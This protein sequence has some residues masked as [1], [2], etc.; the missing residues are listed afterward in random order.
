MI[1][2]IPPTKALDISSKWNKPRQV[3]LILAQ[4][5]PTGELSFW[6]SDDATGMCDWVDADNIRMAR[7]PYVEKLTSESIF[8]H[9]WPKDK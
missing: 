9:Y 1:A 5:S 8:N 2:Y 3:T 6:V 7:E 4:E